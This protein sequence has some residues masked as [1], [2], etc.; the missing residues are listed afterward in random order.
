MYTWFSITSLRRGD[1]LAQAFHQPA[2]SGRK[3][4]KLIL[5]SETNYEL[6]LCLVGT[7]ENG[8]RFE[9]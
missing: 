2:K 4:K 3:E 6:M 9:L 8:M 7:N 1:L 5:R